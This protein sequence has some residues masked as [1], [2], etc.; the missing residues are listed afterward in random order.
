M[1]DQETFA[2]GKRLA[3]LVFLLGL[4]GQIV[5]VFMIGES[6]VQAEWRVLLESIMDT[7]TYSYLWHGGGDG[8]VP[9]AYMPPLYASYLWCSVTIFQPGAQSIYE[10][11]TYTVK[12]IEMLHVGMWILSAIFVSG[13]A[14]IITRNSVTGMWAAAMFMVFPLSIVSPSQITAVNLYL[15]PATALIYLCVKYGYQKAESM[16]IR[17]RDAVLLGIVMSVLILGRAEALLY[18]PI[19]GLFLIK[20]SGW[21][22]ALVY[23][24]VVC[25]TLSPVLVRNWRV[26][27]QPTGITTS[28][29]YNLWRGQNERATSDG[30]G[31]M[32]NE[33]LAKI[34]RL[35][36][37][38]SYEV[39]RDK[40][41]LAEALR[42]MKGNPGDVILKAFDKV[43]AFWFYEADPAHHSLQYVLS[44]WYW[45][46]WMLYLALAILGCY[47]LRGGGLRFLGVPLI[48]VTLTSAIFFVLA[49]YRLHILPVIAVYA[50][51]AVTYFV[52]KV[53][54]MRMR[55]RPGGT[56][57]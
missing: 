36:A 5:C 25:M 31:Q 1:N 17:V 56:A 14:R 15:V 9:S 24:F 42:F 53:Q 50:G 7:G 13:T 23:I 6:E 21:L 40:I 10:I 38:K 16:S 47:I 3:I 46:P 57:L 19:I 48:G 34:N 8:W 18:V 52:K 33:L 2:L 35:P 26:F 20:K 29:G 44:P 32:S 37:S 4:L 51:V 22:R 30:I 45:G 54:E 12:I 27:G 49:R 11:S 43:T 28:G 39:D 55:V 41:F